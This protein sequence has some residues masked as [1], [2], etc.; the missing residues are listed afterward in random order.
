M[1]TLRMLVSSVCVSCVVLHELYGLTY[2]CFVYIYIANGTQPP[3]Q[4][5][6]VNGDDEFEGRVEVLYAGIW[7]TV[8]DDFFDLGSAN[9]VCRQ[10]GYPGALRVAN[11]LEFGQGTGQIWLDDVRCT[12]N[13]TSLENCPRRAFGSHNCFHF[14]D[15]GVECVGKDYHINIIVLLIKYI[16]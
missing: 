9:V 11:F 3:I 14:E 6:L 7:G 12:G 8:C 15:V 5:R 16:C 2:Y 4:V 10:L 1:P 13:E